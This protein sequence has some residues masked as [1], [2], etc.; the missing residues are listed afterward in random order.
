MPL[1]FF[2]IRDVNGVH[3]DETGLDFP[4]MDS[5]IAEGRRALADMNRDALFEPKDQNIEIL[6]RDHGEGPV[7]LAL[8]FSATTLDV[9]K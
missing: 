5:A 3:Q 7:L 8:S 6:I 2:D 9:K 4:N 1:Y